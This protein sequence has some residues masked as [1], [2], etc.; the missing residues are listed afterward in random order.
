MQMFRKNANISRKIPF[1]YEKLAL[2][3]C[4][5]RHVLLGIRRR[6]LPQAQ[7]P[8]CSAASGH[9]VSQSAS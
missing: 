8:T 1:P 3:L 5:W 9:F 7:V 6:N 4:E 2:E